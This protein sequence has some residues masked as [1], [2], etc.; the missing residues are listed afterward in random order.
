MSS[1]DGC[2]RGEQMGGQDEGQ[3]GRAAE[4]QAAVRPSYYGD[5]VYVVLEPGHGPCSLP[6]L[7]STQQAK[8]KGLPGGA[9]TGNL[10]PLRAVPW[11]P[12][13]PIHIEQSRT[14]QKLPERHTCPRRQIGYSTQSSQL[15]RWCWVHVGGSFSIMPSLLQHGSAKF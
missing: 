3:R 14:F 1:L 6:E 10:G 15:R 11:A 13:R 7:L 12:E 8:E 9:W 2:C 5:H 4:T